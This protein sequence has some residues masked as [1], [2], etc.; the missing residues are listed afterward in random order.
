MDALG[1]QKVADGV[2]GI[3]EV[4]QDRE[5]SGPPDVVAGRGQQILDVSPGGHDQRPGLAYRFAVGD[6]VGRVPASGEREVVTVVLDQK[7]ELSF[8]EGT[9][10]LVAEQPRDRFSGGDALEHRS[11]SAH[12]RRGQI[13]GEGSLVLM[14]EPPRAEYRRG[15]GMMLGWGQHPAV[16]GVALSG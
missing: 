7:V 16:A 6:G 10:E 8:V 14:G 1:E 9:F 3:V 11:G 5:Q 13:D 12:P 2:D 15:D 4:S